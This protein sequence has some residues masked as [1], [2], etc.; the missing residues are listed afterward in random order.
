MRPVEPLRASA[1]PADS[2]HPALP[3]ATGNFRNLRR[4]Q[5]LYVDKTRRIADLVHPKNQFVFLARPR[6]FGKSL[7]ISTLEALFQG[8]RELFAGTWIHG[9]D[10]SWEP[11]AVLRLSMTEKRTGDLETSLRNRMR[12]LYQAQGMAMPA[13]DWSAS[14]LLEALIEDLARERKVVVLIDEYDAPIHQNL[15]R[16]DLLPD[17]RDT[18]RQFYGALK[19]CEADLHFAFLTGVTRFA[20]TSVFSGLNNLIDVSFEPAFSDLLGF[21]EAELDRYLAPYVAEM[22]RAQRTSPAEARRG[23]RQWYD[24]YLFAKDSARVYN[25]YSTLHC[26]DKRRFA[27]Y[28]ADSGTPSFLTRLVKRYRKNVQEL[29]GQDARDIG[30]AYYDWEH[31]DLQAIMFQTGYLTLQPV[32]ETEQH[33]TVFPNRE[34]ELTFLT[35]LLAN[36]AQ[37]PSSARAALDALASALQKGDYAAFIAQFNVLLTLIPYEIHLRQHAYYQSLLHLTFTLM[38]FRT[39]SE[40]STHRSRLDTIVELPDKTVILEY[41]L[42]GTAKEALQQIAAKGY[43]RPYLQGNRAVIGLG[44]NF[45]RALRQITEWQVQVYR[46]P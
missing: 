17:I 42:D 7:L 2:P 40:I 11:H 20:R 25:P 45:D 5:L 12:R 39:G 33:V 38:G 34:V 21:T 28:W 37:E 23:L 9:N 29:V 8:T 30:M 19:D 4:R 44:V 3:L 24:G 31:P 6:R 13:G 27:N 46:M 32:L 16:P 36:Y 41:K 22:A 35:A 10:W 14:E 1:M 26:L 18:L 15:E 43:H